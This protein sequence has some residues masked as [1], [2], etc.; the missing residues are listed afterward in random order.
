MYTCM[1]IC[2][3]ACVRV[4]VYTSYI[5]T[6]T[7][8]CT[9]AG[10]ASSA[11]AMGSSGRL[12]LSMYVCKYVYTYMNT[13]MY[14]YTHVSICVYMHICV[15][16]CVRVYTDKFTHIYINILIAGEAR[17]AAAMEAAVVFS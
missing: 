3:Y 4:R 14:I 16:V 5:H 10:E 6:H 8:V 7:Y 17:F 13:Y 2:I 1:Y 12:I 9:V 11:G 15:C